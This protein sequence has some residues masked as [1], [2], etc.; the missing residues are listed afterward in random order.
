MKNFYQQISLLGLVLAF[1]LPNTIFAQDNSSKADNTDD[2]L[3]S[4]EISGLSFRCVGP[5]LTSGRISDFAMN[6]EKPFE[7]YIAVSSGGVWKTENWGT[8]YTP[9]FDSQGSY[10]IGCVTVDPNNPNIVWVGTGENNSS[11][12]SYAGIGMLKSTSVFSLSLFPRFV[13]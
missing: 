11:R 10:S 9:I 1:L 6:P 2:A 7:Y 4:L 13:E 5:A 3:S 8:T 12:S